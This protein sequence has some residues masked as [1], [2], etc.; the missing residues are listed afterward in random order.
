[1]NDMLKDLVGRRVEVFDARG[2]FHDRGTLVGFDDPWLRLENE[3]GVLLFPVHNV[4]LV[5]LLERA[6]GDTNLVTPS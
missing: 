1:M 2:T 4:R 6:A 5:K 3:A